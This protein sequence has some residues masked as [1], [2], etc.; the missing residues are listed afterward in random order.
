MTQSAVHNNAN[1]DTVIQKQRPQIKRPV[2]KNAIS[3]Q[4][5]RA[6]YDTGRPGPIFAFVFL[7][8]TSFFLIFRITRSYLQ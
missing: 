8:M 7:I 3:L 1:T 4:S 6:S 5:R 2:F